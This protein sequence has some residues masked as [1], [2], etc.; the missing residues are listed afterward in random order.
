MKK[1]LYALIGLICV[2]I[3]LSILVASLYFSFQD[4][5]HRFS[6]LLQENNRLNIEL[7]DWIMKCHFA[8]DDLALLRFQHND[9]VA[10]HKHTNGEY[11]DAKFSFYYV[12]K[13]DVQKFGVDQLASEL[14]GLKFEEEYQENIFDCSEMSANL[15]WWLEN[16]GWHAEIIVGECPFGSGEHAWLLVETSSGKYMPVESTTIEVVRWSFPYFDNYF[17]YDHCFETIQDAL[18]Y[19][20]TEFDWWNS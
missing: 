18:A 20:E 2:S 9:Y 12:N 16:N 13:P 14:N 11:E 10:N 4:S 15:E 19:S 5:Q 1:T 6:L 8:E 17:K 7:N 3:T